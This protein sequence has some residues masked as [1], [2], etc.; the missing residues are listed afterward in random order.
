MLN[1]YE[2]TIFNVQLQSMKSIHPKNLE[3]FL[4]IE[5]KKNKFL[6]Y[7]KTKH[8]IEN[9]FTTEYFEL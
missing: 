2:K 9:T 3:K 8:K 6:V 5:I 4:K 7:G 1:G